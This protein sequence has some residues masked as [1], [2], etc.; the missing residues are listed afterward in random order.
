MY[1]YRRSDV[2]SLDSFTVLSLHRS[3]SPFRFAS[4]SELVIGT[5]GVIP[6]D[7]T[8]THELVFPSEMV[9]EADERVILGFS[10]LLDPWTEKS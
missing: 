3:R 7:W 8:M 4:G 9:G 6:Q 5:R 1:V 10:S 2:T